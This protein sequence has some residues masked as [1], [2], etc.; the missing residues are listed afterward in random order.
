MPEIYK[1][2]GASGNM[3][4]A[5]PSPSV[6]VSPR[7]EAAV[8]AVAVKPKSAAGQAGAEATGREAQP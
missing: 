2:A 5:A 7:R 6:I 8:A 4:I 1:Q 3:V